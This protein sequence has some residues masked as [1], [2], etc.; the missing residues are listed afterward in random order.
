MREVVEPVADTIALLSLHDITPAY[1]DDIIHTYDLLAGLG[2]ESM[3]LLV[4]PFY[5]MKK[6]NCFVKGSPFTEFLLS[7][8]L[9]ISLHGYSHITKSGAPC[10][11]CNLTKERAVARL[12]DG[13]S[14]IKQGFGKRPVGF[15]PPMWDAPPRIAKAVREVG[16]DYCVIGDNLYSSAGSKIHG[17]GARI[18]SQ[19]QRTVNTEAAMF[20]IELGGALQVAVHPFDYRMNNLFEL[21]ADLRDRQGY[22]FLGY[23][24]FMKSIH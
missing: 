10:E 17:T 9:E 15:I 21:L 22:R 24:D 4:T 12:K 2:M 19:G 18:I 20:E 23:R 3:T 7:L 6:S 13:I 14:L 11:F 1:E 8:D 5:G 16:L